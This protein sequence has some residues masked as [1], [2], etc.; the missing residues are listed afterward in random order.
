MRLYK[1]LPALLI[2]LSDRMRLGIVVL[3]YLLCLALFVF[4]FLPSHNGSILA[5]PI[6][7]AAWLFKQRGAFICLGCTYLALIVFNSLSVG[8]ILWPTWLL[9]SFLAGIL[10]LLVEG[11]VI[12]LL[13]QAL[14]MAQD[15]D[16]AQAAR[17]KA[18]QAEREIAIAYEHQLHLN[19]LK[20]QFLLN[21]NHELRTPL[22]QV[23]GYLEVLS[24]YREHMDTDQQAK[25]LD[26]ARSG[27][28]ELML[29]I[30][31]VLDATQASSEV[32]PPQLEACSVAQMV[33]DV[34]EPLGPREQQEHRIHV[35]VHDHLMVWA[36][37]QFVH[38]ILRNLLSNAFKYSPGQT[39]V[40][41][42]AARSERT[43]QETD[44]PSQVCLS[45][46]DAGPGIPPAEL[47]LLFGKFVRL[48]RD[49]S[50]T[51]RGSGLGLYIS[52][53]LVEAMNG[54]IW[55]ESTGRAGEG[56]RFC[57]TLPVASQ[58]SVHEEINH[59]V[60]P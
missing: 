37:P 16:I 38:Q 3:S 34:L 5:I 56:S 41:I 2:N 23:Y 10:A 15:L 36:D 40:I 42:N 32:R 24:D 58:A 52:K 54:R 17:R 53:Q 19:Q 20:D 12:G 30:N 26:Q 18:E 21:V 31:H 39:A 35:E 8:S 33:R 1:T 49:L 44:T 55:V 43:A 4:V 47:P 28:Q 48:Q 45:V 29:L 50:G 25:F 11:V 57:F 9:V 59:L 14:D 7:L 46:Q 6:A 27:C 60:S 51:T 13:R 22:T